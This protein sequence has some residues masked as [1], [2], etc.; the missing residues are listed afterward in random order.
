MNKLHSLT[1]FTLLLTFNLFDVKG[2]KKKSWMNYILLWTS[3]GVAPF[4]AMGDEEEIFINNKCPFR[5]CLITSNKGYFKKLEDFDMILFNA[6]NLNPFDS[7]PS[8]RAAYQRYVFVSSTSAINYPVPP[9][10]NGVFNWTWTYRLDS[11]IIFSYII[12][13]NKTG[14]VIGPKREMHWLHPSEMNQT[15]QFLRRKL[16]YKETAIAWIRSDCYTGNLEDDFAWQLKKELSRYEL[17]LDIYGQ[18]AGGLYCSIDANSGPDGCAT[19]LERYYYFYLAI[20]D[21]LSKDYVTDKILL[22]LNNYAV[23]VVYGAANYSR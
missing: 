15:N 10:Y 11:D 14:D 21:A 8:T 19:K 20:E 2:L 7:L 23:P 5:N 18:C 12:V 6:L 4:K 9:S 17:R 16:R 22:A 3:A 1:I 13:K